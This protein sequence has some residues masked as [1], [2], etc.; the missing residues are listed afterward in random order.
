M[1]IAIRRVDIEDE[2]IRQVLHTLHAECFPADSPYT[3]TTGMWWIAFD[4]VTEIGFIGLVPSDQGESVMYLARVGVLEKYRG[5]GL[6]VR[7]TRVAISRARSHGAELIVTDTTQNPA[8]ANSLINCGFK[9]YLPEYPWSFHN[10][11][12]W[13]KPL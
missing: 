10:A 3:P 1:N 9:T 12:Y 7:M 5:N 13:R 8:S 2:L 4:G 6:Q 11:I